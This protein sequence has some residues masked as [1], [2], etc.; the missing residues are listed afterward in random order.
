MKTPQKYRTLSIIALAAVILISGVCVY[1]ITKVNFDYDFE[2]FFPENDPETSFFNEHRKRFETDNDFVLIGIR[3]EAGVFQ[4]DFL[5]D[6]AAIS[7]SLRATDNI[8]EVWGPADLSE[9]IRDPVFGTT[10][11]KQHLRWDQ[12]EMYAI[13]SAKVYQTPEL[14]GNY[15]SVD[16]KSV[17]IFGKTLQMLP[18]ADCDTLADDL[19][20]IVS[21]FDFEEVHVTGRSVGQSYYVDVMQKEMG[22]FIITSFVLVL[23][24]LIIAFRSAWGVV[25]PVFVVILSVVW[26]LGMMTAFGKDIDIMLTVLP[27][28]MFVVGMSDV[29]HILSKYL[30]EL[31]NGTPK[32]D[33]IK[34][35]FKEVGLATLLTSITTAIGF[36]TLLTT[37]VIPMRDFGVYT[38]IGV[39]LA[40]IL[41]FSLLPSLMVLTKEP[42]IATKKK[43]NGLFWNRQL[44]KSFIWVLRHKALVIVVFIGVSGLSI[45]G[46]SNVIVNNYL[47]DDLNEKHQLKQDF[48]YFDQEFSGVRP[49]ELSLT[50]K[51]T[52]KSVFDQDV[53]LVTD[54]I[55]AFIYDTYGIQYIFS[56][57]AVMKTLNRSINEGS[58]K[59]Y[60]IPLDERKFKRLRK[61]MKMIRKA[62]LVRMA[63]TDDQIIQRLSG[64]VGDIGSYEMR[65]KDAVLDSFMAANN[66]SDVFDYQLTGTARLIDINNK[67]LASNMLQGLIIAFLI[68]ALI[69]G[70][71]YKSLRIILISLIPNVMPLL[72]VGGVMG[73]TGIDL[74]VST[75]IVFT[76]IFGIAVDDTIH[77]MSKLRLELAKGRSVIYAIKRTYLS[78]GKAIVVTTLILCGGFL[79]LI[80]SDFQGTF[81]IGFLISI[82]LFLAVIADLT[83][84]PVLLVIFYKKKT[85]SKIEGNKPSVGEGKLEETT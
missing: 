16:G 60:E 26:I 30:E 22:I 57:V 35:T 42:R 6:V 62:E 53:L 78:T 17:A 32:I 43:T 36:L 49:F 3:N 41:A 20:R 77:F 8:L 70:L 85:A 45:L 76:I 28:I 29:V 12:P 7:D 10:F 39:F 61:S 27:T 37:S 63:A 13:D 52:N 19:K 44:R 38:A 11:K 84:L 31:R 15:F 68:I 82:A 51:D 66:Y 55:E 54:S 58:V 73:F 80:M 79:T 1:F 83:L 64:K 69:M 47:L 48:M 50:L 33:A 23:A 14:I 5:K 18:K 24:F 34:L 67:Y 2:K 75:S 21:N 46:I 74:K 56:P 59:A 40:Y 71:L 65:Q 4:E 25:V 81:Y 72:V 9:L